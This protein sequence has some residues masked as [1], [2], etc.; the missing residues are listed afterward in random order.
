[1]RR[2]PSEPAMIASV[3]SCGKKPVSTTPACSRMRATTSAMSAL[4]GRH[5]RCTVVRPL[6]G[7]QSQFVKAAL[8]HLARERRDFDRQHA[9]AESLDDFR[10]VRDDDESER[11]LLDDLLAQQRTAASFDQAQIGVDLVGAI[12][13]EIDRRHLEQRERRDA[14]RARQCLGIFRRA[15]AADVAQR[16]TA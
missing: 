6:H 4:F 12:D 3:A 8:Q 2:M 14:L 5:A 9:D 16:A 1:M 7:L 10:F 15:R 11:L 13:G